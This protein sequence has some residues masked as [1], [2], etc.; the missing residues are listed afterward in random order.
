MNHH[1][2]TKYFQWQNEVYCLALLFKYVHRKILVACHC[3]FPNQ[4]NASIIF[5]LTDQKQFQKQ[6]QHLPLIHFKASP[7]KV[8]HSNTTVINWPYIQKLLPLCESIT[9]T[10]TT[11]YIFELI[12]PPKS[13][14]MQ[15]CLK[16][17]HFL[18]PLSYSV[19]LHQCWSR[20]SS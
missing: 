12:S 2:V 14:L 11:I 19:C 13:Q 3:I 17:D 6:V 16:N 18:F 7:L 9:L 20:E 8:S 10:E 15:N 4:T 5:F 1:L